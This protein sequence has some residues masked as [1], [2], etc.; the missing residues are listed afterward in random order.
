MSEL[1]AMISNFGPARNTV[2]TP[3]SSVVTYNAVLVE[4]RFPSGATGLAPAFCIAAS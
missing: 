2:V 4:P 1:D 3:S